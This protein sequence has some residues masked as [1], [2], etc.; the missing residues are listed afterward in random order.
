MFP[1][2]SQKKKRCKSLFRTLQHAVKDSDEMVHFTKKIKINRLMLTV[3]EK[4]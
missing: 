2:K 4:Q 1:N 3:S